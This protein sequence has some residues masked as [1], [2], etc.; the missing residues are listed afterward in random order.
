M[1]RFSVVFLLCLLW[2]IIGCT[3]VSELDSEQDSLVPTPTINT[4]FS[5][6]VDAIS[7]PDSQVTRGSGSGTFEPEI[8]EPSVT[9]LP[10]LTPVPTLETRIVTIYGDALHENWSL[11]NSR[12]VEY[13]LDET[14]FVHDG[15]YSMSYKPEVEY[16]DLTFTV[17]EDTNDVYLRDDV[18][19]VRFWLYTGD[20]YVNTDALLVSVVGSNDFPYWVQGD[21][22]VTVQDSRPVFPAT[23]LYYLNV[24]EDIPPNTWFQVELW[25]N[26][27][28]YDPEYQY[29]TGVYIKNDED[30][31]R[32]IYLDE[33]ELLMQVN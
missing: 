22:S 31:F 24:E 1:S 7:T 5:T 21:D 2:A 33:V 20:E 25:L 10:T 6:V 26:D 18:L 28:I 8:V 3:A 12:E 11:E 27:L 15:V 29:V 30:F 19:A 23:R 16:A 9:P 13:S 14:V 17:N 4:V 32:T